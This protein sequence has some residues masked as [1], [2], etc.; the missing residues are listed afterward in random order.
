MFKINVMNTCSALLVK[1]YVTL[2]CYNMLAGNVLC[3]LAKE[4]SS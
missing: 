4:K 3:N 1:V 2:K